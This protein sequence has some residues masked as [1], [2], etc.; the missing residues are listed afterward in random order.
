MKDR[1]HGLPRDPYTGEVRRIYLIERFGERKAREKKGPG[2][3]APAL[4]QHTECFVDASLASLGCLGL[5]DQEHV[6]LLLTLRQPVEVSL[7]VHI[8]L[9]RLR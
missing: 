8:S 6:P 7:G 1:K 3:R 4:S 2:L 9:E 5:L